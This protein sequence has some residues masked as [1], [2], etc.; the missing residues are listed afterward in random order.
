[1]RRRLIVMDEAS[2]ILNMR[3]AFASLIIAA[4]FVLSAARAMLRTELAF[5]QRCRRKAGWRGGFGS[6]FGFVVVWG[7]SPSG[8]PFS[9]WILLFRVFR[10]R[11]H[12]YRDRLGVWVGLS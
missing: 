7:W 10:E 2:P 3:D 4:H 6:C 1:M 12:L 8:F 9:V 5:L 11:D